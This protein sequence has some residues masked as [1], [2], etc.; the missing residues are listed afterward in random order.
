MQALQF[1]RSDG[2]IYKQLRDPVPADDE[3]LVEVAFC[4]ICGTDLHILA[5]EAPAADIIVPGHEL[6]GKVISVGQSVHHFKTGTMVAVDPNNHC[7]HCSHC[8]RGDIHFCQ[9]IKPI[10][11]IRNG[12][13]AEYCTVPAVQT[14]PLAE[15]IDQGLAALAEPL[16]CII[17]GW[18]RIAPI[19]SDQYVLIMGAG[20]I[21]LLWASLLRH[22]GVNEIHLTEPNTARRKTAEKIGFSCIDPKFLDKEFS[23]IIDCSGAASA[24]EQAQNYLKIGGK[25]LLFGI[26]PPDQTVSFS[27]FK[28]FQKEWTILGSV[29]NPFTISRA[30]AVL[31]A[32]GLNAK[33]LGIRLFAL[34]EYQSAIETAKQGSALKVIF[35]VRN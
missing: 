28:I 30:L 27:P 24:I 29:I 1:S 23:V 20:I 33:D 12:G 4:G 6:C 19:Q 8:R 9:N 14:Y 2:L 5:G 34:N 11:I 31:P 16:S 17:H 32:L 15:G 13:W 26:V 7:G 25:L 21:G 3:V 22:N 35:A 10:G 18:D